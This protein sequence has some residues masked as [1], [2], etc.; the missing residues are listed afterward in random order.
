MS[1]LLEMGFSDE[2]VNRAL[3]LYGEDMYAASHWC[4]MQQTVGNIPKKMKHEGRHQQTWI[5]SRIHYENSFWDVYE[6]DQTHALL[7]IRNMYNNVLW[8]HM[9]D[10][11]IDWILVRHDDVKPSIPRQLWSRTF[12]T[13]YENAANFNVMPTCA[14][15]LYNKTRKPFW[16]AVHQLSTTYLKSPDV[17]SFCFQRNAIPILQR[18]CVSKIK[19][20]CDIYK[21]DFNHFC[22]LLHTNSGAH[23]VF[24]GKPIFNQIVSLIKMW[25]SPQRELKRRQIWWTDHCIPLLKVQMSYDNEVIKIELFFTNKTFEF[26]DEANYWQHL[27]LQPFASPPINLN[28]SLMIESCPHSIEEPTTQHFQT[29]EQERKSIKKKREIYTQKS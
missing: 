28:L 3:S 16:H 23:L 25:Q 27:L 8:V 18:D 2:L 19:L 11:R 21:I 7:H 5:G 1:F 22:D 13:V 12:L 14:K 17:P 15:D 10:P 20:Y 29:V 6:V 9:S 4:L 26:N 24:N